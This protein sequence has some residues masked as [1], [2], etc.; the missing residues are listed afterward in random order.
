IDGKNLTSPTIDTTKLAD[1]THDVTVTI[2]EPNGKVVIEHKLIKVNNHHS[3]LANMKLKYGTAATV[4]IL[5]GGSL[6]TVVLVGL[7]LIYFVFHRHIALRLM[8]LHVGLEP[9]VEALT[10]SQPL[11]IV[12][13]GQP[14][15]VNP[16]SHVPAPGQVIEP[17]KD[18]PKKSN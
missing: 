15:P 1:G 18:D 7:F 10:T 5:S 17:N 8:P 2:T 3:L 14:K 9:D 13:S 11:N 16:A 12:Q 4:G 6:V